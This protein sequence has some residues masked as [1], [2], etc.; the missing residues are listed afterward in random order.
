M[1]KLQP[2][3]PP[4]SFKSQPPLSQQPASKSWGP[5]DPSVLKIWLEVQLRRLELE[6]WF[7]AHNVIAQNWLRSSQK[8]VKKIY[9]TYFPTFVLKHKMCFKFLFIEKK[10][11]SANWWSQAMADKG[12]KRGWDE[13]ITKI[14]ISW[15]QQKSF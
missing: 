10:N 1:W 3:P 14:W 8:A 2:R 6:V 5:V 13:G 15:E 7:G 4:P 9:K 11:Y 12:E